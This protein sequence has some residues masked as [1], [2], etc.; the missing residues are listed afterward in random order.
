VPTPPVRPCW[1]RDGRWGHVQR[2]RDV[3]VG[4]RAIFGEP[5]ERAVLKRHSSLDEHSRAFIATSSAVGQC[6]GS[7]KGNTPGFVLVLNPMHLVVPDRPGKT[8]APME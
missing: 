4:L 6:D 1:H 2:H 8:T 3:E 5:S 7:P